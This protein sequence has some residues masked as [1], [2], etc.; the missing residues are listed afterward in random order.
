MEG[1]LFVFKYTLKLAVVTAK[2]VDPLACA[3]VLQQGK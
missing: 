3:T 1:V 2:I